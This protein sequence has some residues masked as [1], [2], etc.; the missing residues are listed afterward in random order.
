MHIV[1]RQSEDTTIFIA[2]LAGLLQLAA[3]ETQIDRHKL[4]LIYA[5]AD[6]HMP[7]GCIEHFASAA[8]KN[9]AT[10]I[11]S[12]TMHLFYNFERCYHK[13]A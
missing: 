10:H 7:V 1:Y 6:K 5:W 12:C 13:I 3:V 8:L 9:N 4:H 2:V 11:Y